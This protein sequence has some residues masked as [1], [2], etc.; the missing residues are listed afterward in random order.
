MIFDTALVAKRLIYGGIFERFPDFPYILAHT[1]GA[2]LMM[3]ERLE[4]LLFGTDDPFIDSDT[5]HVRR[6]GLPDADERA[7]LGGNVA[8]LLGF[9]PVAEKK[10]RG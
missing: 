5:A 8:R 2:L 1:G 4:H 3:L 9:G 10:G 7:V 6:L